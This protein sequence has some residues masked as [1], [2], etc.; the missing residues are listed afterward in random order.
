MRL[1][2]RAAATP[3]FVVLV[4]AACGRR[5]LAEHDGTAHATSD[6]GSRTGAGGGAGAGGA[7]AG[8]GHG[9]VAGDAGSAGGT[10]GDTGAAGGDGGTG[11]DIGAAGNDGAAG[12]TTGAT[13]GRGGASGAPACTLADCGQ[14]PSPRVCVDDGPPFACKRGA[15]GACRWHAAGCTPRCT[16]ITGVD[17]CEKVVGCFALILGCDDPRVPGTL[18]VPESHVFASGGCDQRNCPG[19]ADSPD[20]CRWFVVDSCTLATGRFSPDCTEKVCRDR[21]V[22]ILRR[23]AALTGRGGERHSANGSTHALDRGVVDV[24]PAVATGRFAGGSG[25][26]RAGAVA[27][28]VGRAVRAA[29]AERTTGAGVSAGAIWL[30]GDGSVASGGGASGSTI[31][32]AGGGTR[33]VAGAAG[34]TVAADKTGA[35][36]D[37]TFTIAV[38]AAPDA[39]S[40]APTTPTNH[41]EMVTVRRGNSASA[42]HSTGC[43]SVGAGSAIGAIDVLRSDVRRSRP[44]RRRSMPMRAVFVG[45]N[46]KGVPSSSP[47]VIRNQLRPTN[48]TSPIVRP[49]ESPPAPNPVSFNIV[50]L[51]SPFFL[52]RSTPNLRGTR[53]KRSLIAS[54]APN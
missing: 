32:G 54:K 41:Q 51:R 13:T 34:W 21:T 22:Q 47:D 18:C 14:Q 37:R 26:R 49:L 24:L 33:E 38:A 43:A 45:L 10:A 31:T 28:A 46:G 25:A 35:G 44:R 20:G 4:I 23:P 30:G 15:D 53:K 52:V 12:G 50:N 1:A 17:G 9:N 5:P 2:C 27:V 40:T 6:A 3:F 19:G 8:G 42:S 11:N 48:T 7:G 16:E 36:A 39:I 29:G